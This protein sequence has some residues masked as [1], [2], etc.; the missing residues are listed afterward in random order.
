MLAGTFNQPNLE[1]VLM[2]PCLIWYVPSRR[3]NSFPSESEPGRNDTCPQG[4]LQIIGVLDLIEPISTC[5][6]L[7]DSVVLYCH[8]TISL[9]YLYL[10]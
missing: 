8:I 10:N 4:L 6:N 9:C 1:I 7:P 2:P 3:C 5:S